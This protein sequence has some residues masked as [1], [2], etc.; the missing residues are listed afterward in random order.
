MWKPLY[1]CGHILTLKVTKKQLKYKTLMK[2]A[3]S[4]LVTVYRFEQSIPALTYKNI[5]F[6]LSVS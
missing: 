6:K 5:L 4:D 1:A 3:G 2:V